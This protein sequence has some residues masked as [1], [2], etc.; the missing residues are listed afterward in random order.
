VVDAVLAADADDPVDALTRAQ[1]LHAIRGE[2]DLER[3]VIG[4][5]YAEAQK[6]SPGICRALSEQYLPRGASDPL[7][8]SPEG[9]V[10]AMADRLDTIAGCWAA[11][12]VPS[13]SQDPYAL[14]RAANG[15]IRN[16]LEKGFHTSLSDLMNA[17]VEQLPE[18]VRR[19]GLSGEIL[20]FLRDRTAY[21]LREFG[22]TYD[23]VD[24]VLAADA[25]DPVDALTRAQ[26]LHAIR[27]EEDLERLVIG[28]LPAPA[29]VDW[30]AAHAAEQNLH[31]VVTRVEEELED[32]REKKNYPGMLKRLLD[33]R[34]PI[35][36]F[37]D[38][39]MVMSED[40][41]ERDRRLALL[42]EAR[43]L[44]HDFFDP[45]RIVIEGE[46]A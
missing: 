14:R 25:D 7:P 31:E 43:G 2:E 26:A 21:F 28:T 3:L 24:A 42:A 18:G 22:I 12:F 41:A 36:T 30:S 15:I 27:G 1:A 39:V 11:G 5:R 16:C 6:E 17:A 20:E 37:F 34:A 40:P 46:G 19:D 13:G 38:E 8:Q 44:F 35:D 45:A 10:L 32:A 23:V 9:T 29:E 4:A 33:L